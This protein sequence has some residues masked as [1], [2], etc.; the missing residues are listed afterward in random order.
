[1]DKK[2]GMYSGAANTFAVMAFAA[3]MI[4][5]FDFGG[6]LASMFISLSFLPLA[7][8]FAERSRARAAGKTAVAFAAVYV[9]FI[10][11]IYFAQ[12]TTLRNETLTNQAAALL[13][14]QAFGLFFNLNL[15]GYGVMSL[16][17]FFLGLTITPKTKADKVL[18]CLLMIHGIF[19]ISGLVMPISGVFTTMEGADFIGTIVLLVWCAYFAPIGIL[20]FKHFKENL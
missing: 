19:F 12:L 11:I 16:S 4:F 9:T 10:L 7:C 5:G 6:Y 18:K 20:S 17:T 1:M 8:A 14:Y 15:L 3:S 2:I 13:D